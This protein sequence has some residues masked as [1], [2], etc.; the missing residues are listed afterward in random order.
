MSTT[1]VIVPVYNEARTITRFLQDLAEQTQLPDEVVLVDGGSE[2]GTPS[3]IRDSSKSVPFA[4][5]LVECKRAFPG[6]GRNLGAIH[7]KGDLLLFCD[8][9]ASLDR[10]WL[11]GLVTRLSESDIVF[12]R[13]KV[14]A[15]SKTAIGTFNRW[16]F[17][18]PVP[19]SERDTPRCAS[20]SSM[21]ITRTQWYK[22]RPFREDLRA[23]E[24]CVF[25]KQIWA[26]EARYEHVSDAVSWWLPPRSMRELL[27]KALRYGRYAWYSN[28]AQ[29]VFLACAVVVI[30]CGFAYFWGLGRLQGIGYTAAIAL[31]LGIRSLSK[32]RRAGL[33]IDGTTLVSLPSTLF[34]QLAYTSVYLFG[35]AVG[36]WNRMKATRPVAKALE[37]LRFTARMLVCSF[38]RNSRLLRWF[39]RRA[40]KAVVTSPPVSPDAL[41]IE[42]TNSCNASCVI[43][44]QSVTRRSPKVLGI[45]EFTKLLDEAKKAEISRYQL[46]GTNEPLLDPLID[47]RFEECKR[48]TLSGGSLY[49]NAALLTEER[50]RSVARSGLGLVIVSLD[51]IVE[52]YFTIFRQGLSYAAVLAGVRTLL[53]EC[54]RFEQGPMV[55]LVATIWDHRNLSK[56]LAS[57]VFWDLKGLA[58]SIELFPRSSLH[59]WAGAVPL[60]NDMTQSARTVPCHRLWHSLSVNPHGQYVLCCLDY[61]GRHVLGTVAENTIQEVWSGSAL[62]DIRTQHLSGTLEI[63]KF[64]SESD[65]FRWFEPGQENHYLRVSARQR[66]N[67]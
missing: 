2:D 39:A 54:R 27:G 20:V 65:P 45:R 36:A 60:R 38:Q 28:L 32:G 61:A 31:G 50:A 8:A 67:K 21:G 48:R 14:E 53:R 23:G 66:K 47:S 12:G 37:V 29:S 41:L 11:R 58:D 16:F 10:G 46:N 25:L 15:T 51:G 9:G 49:T 4:L 26:S 43:C 7:A 40:S 6:R 34:F 57:E 44:P 35:F 1:S 59:N 13:W 22:L 18:D 64:C 56:V 42:T 3:L 52:E 30:S 62:R 33:R 5:V 24:D 19:R 63:C 17:S 55:S